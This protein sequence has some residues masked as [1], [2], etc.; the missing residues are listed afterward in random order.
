MEVAAPCFLIKQQVLTIPCLTGL[1]S[2]PRSHVSQV[3]PSYLIAHVIRLSSVMQEVNIFPHGCPMYLAL[4]RLIVIIVAK[5]RNDFPSWTAVGEIALHV[6]NLACWTLLL[7]VC[8][9]QYT[10][11]TQ[12]EKRITYCTRV[13]VLILWVVRLGG[14]KVGVTKSVY[15]ITYNNDS[16]ARSKQHC[17]FLSLN[18]R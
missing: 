18:P 17:I 9:Q 4:W 10:A 12:V 5:Q 7:L 13:I 15:A 2:V 16:T 6:R 1:C 11:S 8:L 14:R 3:S